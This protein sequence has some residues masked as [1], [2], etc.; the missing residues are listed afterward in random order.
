MWL[1]PLVFSPLSLFEVNVLFFSARYPSCHRILFSYVF[2]ALAFL[3]FLFATSSKAGGN[4]SVW[5]R[6]PLG[7]TPF[8]MNNDNLIPRAVL[9]GYAVV[10]VKATSLNP[11]DSKIFH[12][13]TWIPFLR[14]ILPHDTTIDIAGVI[15]EVNKCDFK[16]GDRVF[17]LTLFGGAQ[18][19]SLV[20]CLSLGK[21]PSQ[22]T[23]TQAAAVPVIF[24]SGM[25]GLD[26]LAPQQSILIVGSS[27]GCGHA[28]ILLAKKFLAS[29]IY[30]ISS[31]KNVE[32]S[33]EKGCDE[34]FA[35]DSPT[36]LKDL[37]K[38]KGKV[39]YVYDTITSF[40]SNMDYYPIL[41]P[42]LSQ[43]GTYVGLGGLLSDLMNNIVYSAT[44]IDKRRYT[45]LSLAG[46][47]NSNDFKY[48]FDNPDIFEFVEISRVFHGLNVNHVQE[49]FELIDSHR[50]RGKII[51][52]IEN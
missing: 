23:F 22:A 19:F 24:S 1:L 27:G 21:I 12:K 43:G 37:E 45:F 51:L 35:Y 16:I 31:R 42:L 8:V 11:V 3:L 28:G 13:L 4:V 29:K 18:K 5:P 39:D 20:P 10:Q 15:H 17:G 40:S 47:P 9:P 33:L 7:Q 41:S 48:F 46:M 49:A 52:K 50:V 36:F 32:F 34:V 30:C 38:I 2:F 26:L 25:R 14:W 44:G 6:L